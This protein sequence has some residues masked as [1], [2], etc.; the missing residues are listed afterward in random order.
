[1][2]DW[3]TRRREAREN[4][5]AHEATGQV[6][7]SLAVRQGLMARVREGSLTLAAAQAELKRLQ[8]GA[9]AIGQMT[10][11]QARRR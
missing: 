9:K 10:R 2:S 5:R 4:V 1:M 3:L 6:A 7:D 8:R 11:Q